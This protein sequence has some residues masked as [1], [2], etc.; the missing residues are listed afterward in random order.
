MDLLERAT[1][2]MSVPELGEALGIKNHRD[3]R[4][5]ALPRL[6]KAAVVECSGDSVRLRLDWLSALN[7]KREDDQEIDDYE[8]DWNKYEN[9]RKNYRNMLEAR[10]LRR[11]GM[12]VE[13]ISTELDIGIEAARRHLDLPSPAPEPVPAGADGFIEDLEPV[14]EEDPEPEEGEM[15]MPELPMPEMPTPE[16]P[17]PEIPVLIAEEFIEADIGSASGMRYR[18]MLTRWEDLGGSPEDLKRAI[19]D[20]PWR[21]RREPL[22]FDALYV[23]REEVVAA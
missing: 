4:R 12:S 5:R 3:L 13:E 17:E 14:E 22:D 23:C 8:R 10:K 19:G 2:W 7:R 6:E 11:V 9:Q 18:E 1:G 15:P 21:L 16:V 20:G